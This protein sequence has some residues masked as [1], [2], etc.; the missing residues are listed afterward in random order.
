MKLKKTKN[1]IVHHRH[2]LRSGCVPSA[3]DCSRNI[4]RGVGGG[5][6]H[7]GKAHSACNRCNDLLFRLF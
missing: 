5:R 7:C 6:K 3:C 1:N 4:A 2:Y